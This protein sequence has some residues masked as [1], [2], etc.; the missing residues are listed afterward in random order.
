MIQA[1][2]CSK[3]TTGSSLLGILL[4]L[5]LPWAQWEAG[6][7]LCLL[8]VVQNNIPL[9]PWTCCLTFLTLNSF[10]SLY[11]HYWYHMNI[12]WEHYPNIISCLLLRSNYFTIWIH[13]FEILRNRMCV[14]FSS[15]IRGARK[16]ILKLWNAADFPKHLCNDKQE[17]TWISVVSGFLCCSV[18]A[19]GPI[20]SELQG[21]IEF[22]ASCGWEEKCQEGATT[23]A[24]NQ[25]AGGNLNK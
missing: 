15:S 18:E 23:L 6:Q 7:M 20:L 11:L 2:Q 8:Q 17:G 1:A 22:L 12:F 5:P 13:P 25:Q 21:T 24:A 4:F 14:F 16:I 10:Q 19:K 3:C 9:W